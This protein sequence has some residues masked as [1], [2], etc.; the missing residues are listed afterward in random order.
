MQ[1]EKRGSPRIE[2]KGLQAKM[3]VTAPN[4]SVFIVE[5]YVLDISRS[6][7]KVRAKKPLI[8]DISSYVQ[9]EVILPISN[10]PFTVNAGVIRDK[11]EVEFGLR[12]I[13][14][15][16]EDPIDILINECEKLSISTLH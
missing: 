1:D 13:D 2:A 6:G 7:I 9:L 14:L 16:P 5:I 4:R 10:V 8:V 11:V 15:H 12:Y 3:T